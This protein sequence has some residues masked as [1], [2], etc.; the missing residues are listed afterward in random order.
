MAAFRRHRHVFRPETGSRRQGRRGETKTILL[1]GE[2]D[3]W[4]QRSGERSSVADRNRDDAWTPSSIYPLSDRDCQFR[5]YEVL[6]YLGSPP[7]LRLDSFLQ[8]PSCPKESSQREV[9]YC[10]CSPITAF[11]L[12]WRMNLV[13]PDVMSRIFP[14]AQ[15]WEGSVSSHAMHDQQGS[16]TGQ[17]HQI[18]S[19]ICDR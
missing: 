3:S 1:Y 15:A 5:W 2:Q 12:L 11:L 4:R 8:A 6:V 9:S 10:H 18:M 17:D 13:W 14:A 19:L 7:S 16:P